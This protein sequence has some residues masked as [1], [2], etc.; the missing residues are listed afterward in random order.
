MGIFIF[1]FPKYRVFWNLKLDFFPTE[2]FLKFFLEIQWITSLSTNSD[3]SFKNFAEYFF[4]QNTPDFE[5]WSWNI[6]R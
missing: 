2:K 5:S 6:F 1:F 3:R 4:R